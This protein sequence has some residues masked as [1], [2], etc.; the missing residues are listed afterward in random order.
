[1]QNDQYQMVPYKATAEAKTALE[2]GD[3]D[4]VW[5]GG[6][7][8]LPMMEKE[9]AK[10]VAVSSD[11]KL[12][13]LPSLSKFFG[14]EVPNWDSL[15]LMFKVGGPVSRPDWLHEVAKSKEFT[16]ALATRRL[17]N[18]ALDKDDLM[19]YI[20]RQEKVLLEKK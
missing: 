4:M 20:V 19:G 10:C 14:R 11:S 7:T 17:I 2:A 6:H 5:F 1:M 12:A 18:G 16:D 3:L 8:A 15:V 9:G 13:G